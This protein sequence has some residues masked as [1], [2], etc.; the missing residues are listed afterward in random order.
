MA[1]G[2][3]GER[4]TRR[5]GEALRRS[6]HPLSPSPSLPLSGGFLSGKTV[7]VSAGHGWY[8]NPDFESWLTQRPVWEDLVEDFN[9]AEAVN[10]YLLPYL[11]NAGA[12]VWTVRERDLN[13]QEITV[14][15]DSPAYVQVGEWMTPTETVTASSLILPWHYTP[16]S[17]TA[18]ATATWTFTPTETARHAVY[19][20]YSHGP[21]RAPD[22]RYHIEHAGG[23]TESLVD[24]TVHGWTWRYLG[25][26][27][28]HAG[29]PA[30]VSLVNISD[31][32][33]RIVSAGAVRI[34]GGMGS[35]L[36]GGEPPSP[37]TSGRPRWEEAARYWV[38]FQGAP[39]SV[40]HPSIND[41]FDDVTARSRY[42]EWEK[43]EGEDAIFVSWHT[44][45]S[46]SHTQRGTESHI[47]DGTRGG[48]WTPGSDLLQYFLHRTLVDDIRAA[49]D[50]NWADGGMLAD[51]FGEVRQLESM[52]GVLMEIAY[53]DVTAEAH[54]LVDPRFAQLTA[55]AI[56][57]GSVRYFAYRDQVEPVF[58]PEPP[59]GLAAQNSGAGQVTLTWLPSPTDGDGPLGDTATSY[60]VYTSPDGFAWDDGSDA[61]GTSHALTGL[62]PGQLVFVRVTGVNAGG[63]SLPSPTL[64]TRAAEDGRASI[65]LVEA[66]DRNDRSFTTWQD[67]GVSIADTAETGPSRRLFADRTNRR[68]YAIQHGIAITRP[69]D[70]ATRNMLHASSDATTPPVDLYRYAVADWMAGEESS[71]EEPIPVGASTIALNSDEQAL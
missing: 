64:A 48:I 7:Y 25:T 53:H 50:P 5:Q 54:A 15:V 17:T 13:P 62:A 65:L 3:Q 27:P 23:V 10:Q 19:A 49:W 32:T 6:P 18:T 45:G 16:V 12:D 8:W 42:A 35:E 57:R 66:F 68:D 38:K 2:R 11:Y 51:N 28:F 69:F 63:E 40:Y 61:A 24:Q 34:G 47:Y 22:A 43:P 55:R 67:D 52:P 1:T 71:P 70:S 26:Y 20:W 14:T 60:R 4:E 58:L 46:L 37:S 36:G 21:D 9:N 59:G 31:V 44:N 41:R 33:D 30:N 56:Y 29:Q 39:S